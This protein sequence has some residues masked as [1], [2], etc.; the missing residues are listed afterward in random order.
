[1]AHVLYDRRPAE[2]PPMRPHQLKAVHK[3]HNGSI[4]FGGVGSGKSRV[5]IAYYIL[6]ES[7][8]DIFVITTAKKRDT[9][10]W[11]GEA[12]KW[13]IGRDRDATNAGIIT[14]DSWN[15]IEKYQEV[16][17]AFFI[18]DEQRLVGSGAWVKSFLRIAKANKWILLSATPGDTWLDYIPV[19]VA[20]GFYKNRTEF[21]REHVIYN[22]FTKY[23][24]VDK[25]LGVAKLIRLR[26]HILVEMP[27]DEKHTIPHF[28][29]LTAEYD[30]A[31]YNQVL[32]K[33]WHVYENRPLR[34]VSE[35]FYVLRKVTNSDPSRMEII[36][37]LLE[38]HPR[39]VIF[40]NF[41]YELEL[42]RQLKELTPTT[43]WN[44]HKHQ[45]ISVGTDW[46]F[47][48]QYSA[49]AEGWNCTT[50]NAM[51]FY[52]LP[53]SF[54]L[55]KQGQGRIDRLN[56]PYTDLFYFPIVSNSPVDKGVQKALSLKKN[57]NEQDLS[58]DL[59]LDIPFATR[60]KN[61]TNC[62]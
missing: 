52:S 59:S 19:F 54:K 17:D 20:N 16:K 27:Y 21:K 8:K 9:L 53:Y 56:T 15:N 4:L 18:F 14:V 12:V 7:P 13:C 47:L 34:D 22:T 24:K 55:Y 25:Y 33:R 44:G 23:P 29:T 57:F 31:L 28:E 26:D 3:L 46:T 11:Q 58:S 38:K 1:M 42:L 51:S 62:E 32:K 49:G 6:K 48:V 43:E 60:T 10:D 30:L 2:L 40:Y 39:L 35:M 50:T 41:D 45:D 37:K 36:K 5:A 61:H